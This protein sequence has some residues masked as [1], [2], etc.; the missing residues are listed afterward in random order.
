MRKLTIGPFQSIVLENAIPEYL[1]ESELEHFY[2]VESL[3]CD[4]KKLVEE[5]KLF[6]YTTIYFLLGSE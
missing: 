2:R 4:F 5:Q 1:I 6:T 3:L